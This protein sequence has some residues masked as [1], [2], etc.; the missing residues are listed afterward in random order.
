MALRWAI[1]AWLT[2]GGAIVSLGLAAMVAHASANVYAPTPESAPH[3]VLVATTL[4]CLVFSGAAFGMLARLTGG[5]RSRM[6]VVGGALCGLA[7]AACLALV[8]TLGWAVPIA[9]PVRLV[10]F[11][12]IV[13]A[14]GG[15]ATAWVIGTRPVARPAASV[16]EA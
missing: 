8:Y 9:E 12:T 5:H 11:V 7:L 14:G 10:L 1:A 15:S 16:P 2:L 13:V 3:W 4:A 6:P